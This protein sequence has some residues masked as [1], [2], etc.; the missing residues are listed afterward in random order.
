MWN[1]CILCRTYLY[2]DAKPNTDVCIYIL[3]S[4]GGDIIRASSDVPTYRK[5]QN[6]I[7]M[8]AFTYY[9]DCKIIRKK[10]LAVGWLRANIFKYKYP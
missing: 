10:C 5:M 8:Y 3:F 7:Q 4:E 2:K 9:F 6:K 1:L